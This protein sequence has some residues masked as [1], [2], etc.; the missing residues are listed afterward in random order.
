VD[1]VDLQMDRPHPARVYDYMLGGKDNFAADRKTAQEALAVNPTGRAGPLE[2]RAFMVRAVRYLAA[3]AGIRQFLDIGTGIPTSPNVHEVAQSIAPAARIAYADNDP[4]VLSHARA[5]MISSPEGRTLYVDGDMR[6]PDSILKAAGLSEVIDLGRPVGLLL[7]AVLHL[8]EDVQEAYG[9]CRR[10]VAAMPPGSYLV[11]THLTSEL[12]PE[13]LG[14]VSDSMRQ[15]GM[16]LMPRSKAEIERFFDGLDLVEPGIEIANRWRP[17]SQ[18]TGDDPAYD[19]DVSIYCG[20]ARKP[21][22]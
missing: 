9:Y 19:A 16:T 11:L 22:P 21:G 17:E 8:I 2:N 14:N 18:S 1:P 20:V 10:Y 4:I 6:E 13:R 5:L 15:R 12:A 7:V 3:E